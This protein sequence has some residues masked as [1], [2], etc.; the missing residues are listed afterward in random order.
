MTTIHQIAVRMIRCFLI[1]CKDGYLMID[2]NMPGTYDRFLKKL[3]KTGIELGDIKYLLL[4]H[5]H[6]DHVGFAAQIIHD[7][8]ARLIVHEGAV[9]IIREGQT[10]NPFINKKEA[11]ARFLNVWTRY[12]MTLLSAIVQRSWGYPPVA[13]REQDIVIHGDTPG[14]LPDI[15]IDGTILHTPGHTG[16]SISVVLADGSAFVGDT[17][18]NFMPWFGTHH[19]P[20][21]ALDYADV[22]ASWRKLLEHGARTIYTAHGSPFGAEKLT[23]YID[24]K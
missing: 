8:P 1:P 13:T 23:R 4:T 24:Q 5:Y 10:Q 12:T 21:Y 3:K 11:R 14:L 7:T 16:D 17:A 15:G 18:M 19:R 22:F 2:T 20:I 6:D 9:P